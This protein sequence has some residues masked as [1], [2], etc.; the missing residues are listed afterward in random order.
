MKTHY[1]YYGICADGRLY[2][3]ADPIMEFTAKKDA[4]KFARE[5]GIALSE[6]FSTQQSAANAANSRFYPITGRPIV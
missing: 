5:E 6:N 2:G 1:Y 3:P 4:A